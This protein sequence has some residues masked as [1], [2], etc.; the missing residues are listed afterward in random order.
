MKTFLALLNA[1]MLVM[2][3]FFALVAFG[4]FVVFQ[5]LVELEELRQQREVKEITIPRRWCV[6][7]DDG[8]LV[9]RTQYHCASDSECEGVE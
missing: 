4:G 3:A 9:C 1:P 2:Y 5:R 6:T 8:E 7:D